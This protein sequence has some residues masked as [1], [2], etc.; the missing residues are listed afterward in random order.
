MEDQVFPALLVTLLAL[1]LPAADQA[2]I[3]GILGNTTRILQL[4]NWDDL[5]Q[6]E[7]AS[8]DIVALAPEDPNHSGWLA[9]T[10]RTRFPLAQLLFLGD[11]AQLNLIRQQL[12]LAGIPKAHWSLLRQ[13]RGEQWGTVLAEIH[14]KAILRQAVEVSPQAGDSAVVMRLQSARPEQDAQFMAS[15]LRHAHEAI[16]FLDLKG[17]VTFC[18]QAAERLYGLRQD[19]MLGR[20]ILEWIVEQQQEGFMRTVESVCSEG[21]DLRFQTTHVNCDGDL[22]P[23][24]QSLAPVRDWRGLIMGITSVVH[25]QRE[26]IEQEKLRIEQA[27]QQLFVDRMEKMQAELECRIDQRTRD[28]QVANEELESF[29]YS[30]SHDLRAPLRAIEGFSAILMQDFASQLPAEGQILL[31]RV[32]QAIYRMNQL[33]DDLLGLSMVSRHELHAESVDLSQISAH[34]VGRLAAEAPERQ[35]IWQIQ[36][37]VEAK[38]DPHLLEV[39]LENLLG[40]A[41]KYSR[42]VAQ[43]RIELGVLP[44]Q[45][46]GA[47]YFV[48]DNGAGFDM[49]YAHKLFT[50]FQRLHG[51]S[52]FE[53]TGIGLATVARIVRRH[54]GRVWAESQPDAGSTFYF[55][56]EA[57]P[58]PR[59]RSTD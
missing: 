26:H 11:A 23:V 54:G 33:V 49:Q 2:R 9:Q 34:I 35:V 4:S 18:N 56:L 3:T 24:E 10:I 53:G 47:V 51:A 14:E 5:P 15:A 48:R 30:V 44:D 13:E 25:D 45:P 46:E 21:S 28:L 27:S 42:K 50:P 7:S 37:E 52:E 41:W 6:E 43:S 36:P 59:R 1:D 20:P 22:I 19:D 39:L 57:E 38:G 32:R 58:L 8:I 29:S 16:L 55:T 40:N 12:I 31:Q 17:R